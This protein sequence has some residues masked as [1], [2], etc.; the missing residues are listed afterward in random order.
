MKKSPVF[1]RFLIGIGVSLIAASLAVTGGVLAKYAHSPKK[2]SAPV[3]AKS[4]YF[5][6]NYLTEDNHTYKLSEGTQEISFALYNY[7]NDLRISG[8]DSEYTVTVT[9][10]DPS[11]TINGE[12]LTEKTLVAPKEQ[13][14]DTVVTL[15]DLNNG[16]SYQV[17]VIAKG[18]YEK[19]LSATFAVSA[20]LNGLFMNTDHNNE[21]YVILT[22][23]TENINGS[24]TISAPTG[25]IPDTTDP[26]LASI[27]NYHD[28]RY[29]EFT[30]EDNN[31]FS[32]AFSSRSYRFFKTS[33]YDSEQKFT[34][35]I[36]NI[37]AIESNIP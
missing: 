24:V 10:E 19:V 17:T 16:Y 22:V 4:F 13:K 23:W 31:S 9:S 26:I 27:V 37:S 15:G 20:S 29:K 3:I 14:K 33:E 21:S 36:E 28:G 11:F 30:F 1:K 5:E 18:G 32:A 34:V 35:T 6:S 8:I 12:T 25:L 7:E 2:E